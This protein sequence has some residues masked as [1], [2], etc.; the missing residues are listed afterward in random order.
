MSSGPF[1]QIPALLTCFPLSML[2]FY[3][4]LPP[5][6]PLTSSS[7]SPHSFSLP[8]ASLLLLF[9][10]LIYIHGA[11]ATARQGGMLVCSGVKA[12]MSE[13][14]AGKKTSWPASHSVS[15]RRKMEQERVVVGQGQCRA[16]VGGLHE[17]GQKPRYLCNNRGNS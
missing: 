10:P 15:R 8:H 4:S 1:V 11:Q 3:P 17:H 14:P 6:F 5:F 7:L 16:G 13:T 9:F 12:L 2:S